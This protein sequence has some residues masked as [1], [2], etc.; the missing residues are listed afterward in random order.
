MSRV[1]D[2]DLAGKRSRRHI[3]SYHQV[4]VFVVIRTAAAVNTSLAQCERQPEFR[5]ALLFHGVPAACAEQG[6]VLEIRELCHA[7]HVVENYL[8]LGGVVVRDPVGS[9]QFL[10]VGNRRGHV[11]RGFIVEVQLQVAFPVGIAHSL[12]V[13][14]IRAE[15]GV[16][17]RRDVGGLIAPAGGRDNEVAGSGL[18]VVQTACRELRQHRRRDISGGL[19][20]EHLGVV[21]Q[22]LYVGNVLAAGDYRGDGSD[23]LAGA[24]AGFVHE[25]AFHLLRRLRLGVYRY[26]SAG[27]VLLYSAVHCVVAHAAQALLGAD[28]SLG[29]AVISHK[30]RVIRVGVQV[31]AGSGLLLQRHGLSGD[32]GGNAASAVCHRLQGNSGAALDHD[33]LG[34]PDGAQHVHLALYSIVYLLSLMLNDKRVPADLEVLLNEEV[35]C[36]VQLYPAAVKVHVEVLVESSHELHGGVVGHEAGLGRRDHLE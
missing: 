7:R 27:H 4:A 15:S 13:Q 33:V 3:E 29:D 22:R 25:V 23:H 31:L 30:L 2:D 10:N 20:V 36:L 35:S 21:V 12:D 5:H 16:V 1:D 32:D 28:Y 24:N 6:A 11:E 26:A 18:V 14:R 34:L 17:E 9:V 8:H 19:A